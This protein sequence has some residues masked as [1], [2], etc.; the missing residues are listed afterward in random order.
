LGQVSGLKVASMGPKK[1]RP[2]A[3]AL[4]MVGAVKEK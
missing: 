2:V 4:T 3:S 1:R